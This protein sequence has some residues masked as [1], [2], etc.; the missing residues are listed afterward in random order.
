M[1]LVWYT[2]MVWYMHMVHTLYVSGK[3]QISDMNI[4]GPYQVR[5][6]YLLGV[7]HINTWQMLIRTM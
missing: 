2:H 1:Y 7:H 6:K 5:I 4:L 3:F